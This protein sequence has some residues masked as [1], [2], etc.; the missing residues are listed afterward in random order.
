MLWEQQSFIS[1][2]ISTN[3]GDLPTFSRHNSRLTAGPQ[4]LMKEGGMER[5]KERGMKAGKEG[6]LVGS[7]V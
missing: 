2:N 1:R 6:N 3:T 5:G 4:C 7:L